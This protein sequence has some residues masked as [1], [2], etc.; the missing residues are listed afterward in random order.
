MSFRSDKNAGAI[1]CGLGIAMIFFGASGLSLVGLQRVVIT[2]MPRIPPGPGSANFLATM[3]GGHKILLIYLPLMILGGI[4]FAVSGIYIRRGLLLARRLAQMNTACGY[5]WGICYGVSCWELSS[6]LGPP[7]GMPPAIHFP[8][9]V[10]CGTG[11]AIMLIAIP[12][13]FLWILVP[14]KVKN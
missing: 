2:T 3:E 1:I 4:V 8:F 11:G 7:P 13:I 14:P 6:Q 10:F 9:R 5:V 12:T